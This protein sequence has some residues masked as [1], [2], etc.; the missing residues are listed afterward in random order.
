MIVDPKTGEIESYP[1]SS[2]Y[3]WWTVN[4][5]REAVDIRVVLQLALKKTYKRMAV[6]KQIGR[7]HVRV[8]KTGRNQLFVL[9]VGD[10]YVSAY[11]WDKLIRKAA[12]DT[13]KFIDR[14]VSVKKR[15]K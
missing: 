8:F 13:W 9:R 15:W 3:G 6:A 7:P 11:S 10:R 2:R 14:S 5:A 12:W 1:G 4:K